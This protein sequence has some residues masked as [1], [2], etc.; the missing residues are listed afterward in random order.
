MLD[1][2]EGTESHL[3]PILHVYDAVCQATNVSRKTF[4]YTGPV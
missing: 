2:T 1:A 4:Q 3:F